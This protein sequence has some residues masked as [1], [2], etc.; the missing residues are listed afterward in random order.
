MLLSEL[1]LA[2]E[3]GEAGMRPLSTSAQGGLLDASGSERC[4]AYAVSAD[5]AARPGSTALFPC[6]LVSV[7]T[8]DGTDVAI[9][10]CLLGVARQVAPSCGRLRLSAF[11]QAAGALGKPRS[12][13]QGGGQEGWGLTSPAPPR[14]L[15][16]PVPP[17][18]GVPHQSMPKTPSTGPHQHPLY[19]GTENSPSSL[20]R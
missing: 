1:L 4:H 5:D 12:Q 17:G 8:A 19:R 7:A 11:P 18:N 16:R 15:P 2:R 13:V 20:T 10:F 9:P 14:A 3:R 6:C